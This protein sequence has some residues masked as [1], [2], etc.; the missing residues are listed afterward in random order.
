MA[1]KKP[2]QRSGVATK[3]AQ[4]AKLLPTQAAPAQRS[5]MCEEI[6]TMRNARSVEQPVR[7]EK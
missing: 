6:R 7:K 2:Q 5:T 4:T 1:T 3:V